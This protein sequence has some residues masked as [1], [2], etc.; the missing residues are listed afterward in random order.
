MAF[1]AWDGLCIA[2]NVYFNVLIPALLSPVTLQSMFTYLQWDHLRHVL[3]VSRPVPRRLTLFV[4]YQWRFIAFFFVLLVLPFCMMLVR[5]VAE[6]RALPMG[7]DSTGQRCIYFSDLTIPI[8]FGTC[9]AENHPPRPSRTQ[10]TQ[11]VSPLP[12]ARGRLC[13]G[14]QLLVVVTGHHLGRMCVSTVRH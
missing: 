4:D 2:R 9:S 14:G 11:R 7:L 12:A 13:A 3:P 6:E 10:G 8:Y 5:Y 1:P